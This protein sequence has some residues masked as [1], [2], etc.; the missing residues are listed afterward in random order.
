MHIS[1]WLNA[2]ITFSPINLI[3]LHQYGK[4]RW[5]NKQTNDHC[6][7]IMDAACSYCVFS[8]HRIVMGDIFGIAVANCSLSR[9]YN[10]C[11]K[12]MSKLSLVKIVK[13]ILNRAR[14]LKTAHRSGDTTPKKKKIN[15]ISVTSNEFVCK[16]REATKGGKKDGMTI[17]CW[18]NMTAL[19]IVQL[20]LN[21]G[22]NKRPTTKCG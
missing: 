12:F 22:R 10:Y 19:K 7:L 17:C 11:G 14:L 15:S 3:I 9:K 20:L 21:T 1:C 6:R 13:V 2:V 8:L 18:I 5:A 16:Q 4:W